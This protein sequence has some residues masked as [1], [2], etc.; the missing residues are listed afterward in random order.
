MLLQA[1]ICTC[2]FFSDLLTI[3]HNLI[4][5]CSI[6]KRR[7]FMRIRI[8]LNIIKEMLSNHYYCASTLYDPF[9]FFFFFLIFFCKIVIAH[10]SSSNG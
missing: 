9:N 4:I 6:D 1:T 8:S 7:I 3:R 10:N 2:M 5:R